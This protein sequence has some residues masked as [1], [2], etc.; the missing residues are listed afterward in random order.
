M[1]EDDGWNFTGQKSVATCFPQSRSA[2]HHPLA[3]RAPSCENEAIMA[4]ET[5]IY[6]TRCPVPTASGVAFQTGMLAEAFEGSGYDVPNITELGEVGKDVHYTHSI[7]MFMREGGVAP[8]VWARANGV[9][10][11]VLGI[12]FMEEYQGVFVRA[13]DAAESVADL[14][15][16]RLA[17]PVWPKLVFNFWRFAALKGLTSALR[18]HGVP[19]DAVTFVDVVEGWDPS[20]RRNV[21]KHD[22][23]TPARC[24]YRGQLEAL[25][26]GEVDAVFGKGPEAGLL[27]REAEGRVRLLYDV[28]SAPDMADRINNSTPRLLTTSRHLVDNHFDAAVRYVRALLRATAWVQDNPLEARALIARECSIDDKNIETY[29]EPNYREKFLPHL[30]GP[31]IEAVGVVKSFLLENGFITRDFS[32]ED[33]IDPRP[34]TEARRLEG[35]G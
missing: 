4:T 15:G 2:S 30:D 1:R 17:L 21:G 24:E 33:W 34:L 29:L 5:S 35:I 9:D 12:T 7:D 28:R 27:E 19:R 31:M 8:P 16:R 14:A 23:A 13:G 22:L 25:L 32:V 20:E 26:A 3:R 11:V 10:S 18:V 6:Y